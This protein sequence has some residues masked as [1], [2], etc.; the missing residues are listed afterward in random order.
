MG[1]KSLVTHILQQQIKVFGH[2]DD[3]KRSVYYFSSP[4]HRSKSLSIS[5]S[6]ELDTFRSTSVNL[7]VPIVG[8]QNRMRCPAGNIATR[9]KMHV[10]SQCPFVWAP[11]IHKMTK[12]RGGVENPPR[13]FCRTVAIYVTLPTTE[14]KSARKLIQIPLRKRGEEREKKLS[15]WTHQ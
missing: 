15:M 11:K 4:K 10:G 13:N 9:V 14:E 3:Q 7:T 5:P 6:H 2:A 12:D 8:Q 1:Q